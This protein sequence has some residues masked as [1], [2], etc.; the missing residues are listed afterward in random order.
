LTNPVIDCLMNHRSIRKFKSKPIESDILETILRA[1]TRAAT[2]GNLQLYTMVIVDD[3]A[4]KKQMGFEN[5]PL[6]IIALV[7][8][9]RVSRWFDVNDTQSYCMDSPIYLFLGYW[10]AI[11]AL[12]N[13]V[14]AS[15]S[16]GLGTYYYGNILSMDIK[17]LLNTPDHV[18]PA[19]MVCIGY[20]DESPEPR[21]RLPLDAVVHHNSYRIQTDDEIKEYY[22]ERD[23]VWETVREELREKLA[24][25]NIFGIA[26]ALAVQ[27][28]S[29]KVVDMRSN[30]VL[31]NLKKAKFNITGSLIN[32]ADNG[33]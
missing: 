20:P 14:V 33:C 5:V 24:R 18:F 32:H 21:M 27:R 30:G 8:L 22:S 31:E 7:D 23:A 9:Y 1:G 2:A 19:G 25:Q 6:V 29:K 11:I 26:Q 12:Q 16:I 10:D 15:E 17:K 3:T 28:F 13:V 4:K